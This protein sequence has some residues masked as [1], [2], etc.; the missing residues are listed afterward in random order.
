M[1]TRLR[2]TRPWEPCGTQGQG[3]S[4][5]ES[6]MSCAVSELARLATSEPSDNTEGAHESAKRLVSEKLDQL[7]AG[8]GTRQW[9]KRLHAIAQLVAEERLAPS[10]F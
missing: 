10:G 5:C 1:G 8:I 9:V 3:G 2:I 7:C 4:A 6:L